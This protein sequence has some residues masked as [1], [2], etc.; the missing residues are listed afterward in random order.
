MNL[1][2]AIEGIEGVRRFIHDDF[3]LSVGGLGDDI[4]VAGS[5][6]GET[7]A[8]LGMDGG[9]LFIQPAEASAHLVCNGVPVTTSSWLRDGDVLDI[10]NGHISVVSDEFTIRLSVS[11]PLPDS[12][13]EPPHITPPPDPRP[14]A[15]DRIAVAPTP[16]SPN[17]A[18]SRRAR[19]EG[20][21][22]WW[23]RVAA[24]VLM[25]SV[26]ALWF[27]L[28]SNSVT[29]RIEPAPDRLAVTGGFSPRIGGRFLLRPG[30]YLVEAERADHRPLTRSITVSSDDDQVFGFELE[31]LPGLVDI[32][33]GP[34]NGATV[35]IDGEIVGR[36]PMR[37]V[38]LKVGAHEIVIRADRHQVHSEILTVSEPGRRSSLDVELVPA[39][40]PVSLRSNPSGA[41]VIVDGQ[42]TG[43]TPLVA[44]IG[45]GSHQ[46]EFRLSGHKTAVRHLQVIADQPQ[47][48]PVVN[49]DQ[50]MA[51]LSVSSAP[52]GATMT[53]DG[54]FAGQ[55]PSDLTLKP[56][57][58]HQIK[59][60]KAGFESRTESV[61]IA[62]GAVDRIEVILEPLFGD[63]EI[64]STPTGA[65]IVIDGEVRGT[66]SQ[67]FR[68]S[69]TSHHIEVRKEG[70]ESFSTTI[71]PETGLLETV[72]VSLKS[73]ETEPVGPAAL[74]ATSQGA[75]LQ[76]I[77]PGA[78]RM[79][80]SRREPGRRA[81][82]TIRDVVITT[83]FY[84]AVHEVTNKL[85]GEFNSA[86]NSGHGGGLNLQG[87]N[88]PVVRV[89]WEDAAR[90]CNWLSQK[91]G[92]PPVY[93]ERDGKLLARSPIP[94]GYRL[95]TEA[96]WALASR[97][98]GGNTRRKYIWGDA[99]PIPK[100]A[101]NY[102]D[103]TARQILGS[104]LPDY[105]DGFPVTSPVGSF[106]PNGLG[107]FDL[108]GNVS[109]WVHDPYTIYPPLT[110]R[111]EQ[112][113]TGPA[114]GEY[115]VI[116]GG[117]WMDTQITRIRLSY[118]DYGDEPRPNLGFRIARSAR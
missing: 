31:P 28:S 90:Y 16:Y 65:E 40:A 66:T 36:T 60:T 57:V 50:A 18:T 11:V 112:D 64:H 3:P 111:I 108:G 41:T 75:V 47:D 81:N 116:R 85:F 67:S 35:E 13:T 45:A 14:P 51:R 104:A 98:A 58:D 76:L 69:A 89:S 109:E 42:N 118:R 53:V 26:A 39:W 72:R 12:P 62:A 24:I 84:L 91:E 37:D 33:S 10:A 117:S 74:T 61:R 113:P 17:R 86:H 63:V 77:S 21:S 78:V 29:I 99:L 95:P 4:V 34:L 96:E 46:L 48:F 83:P 8:F 100:G 106:D 59:I 115:H 9:S 79:G 44:E 32:T 93:I 23:R 15:E 25:A 49:L 1:E 105:I 55:T 101:G 22:G 97:M 68:L 80:A 82:E 88:Q 5:P 87:N 110:G 94:T 30:E 27:V 71:N 73:L 56:G 54:R 52:G 107:L 38:Q 103:A 43:T 6:A 20:R 70:F 114:Q 19:P 102:G 2:V 92:L 7:V